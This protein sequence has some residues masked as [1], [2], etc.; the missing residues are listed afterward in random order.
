MILSVEFCTGKSLELDVKSPVFKLRLLL[1]SDFVGG[2]K[3]CEVNIII[4]VISVSY[5]FDM[6]NVHNKNL[7]GYLDLSRCPNIIV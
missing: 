5:I 6:V 1:L 2:D 3:I 4:H 7:S